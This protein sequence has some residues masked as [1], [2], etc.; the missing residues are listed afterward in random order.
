MRALEGVVTSISPDFWHG[1]RVLLTGATGFKGSWLAIWLMRLGARVSGLGLAAEPGDLFLAAGLDRKLDVGILDIRDRNALA[2]FVR[3]VQPE[4]VL[5]LAAQPLVRWS[6]TLPVETFETNVMGTV[7][8]LEACREIDGLRT[9]VAITTDKV[10]ANLERV[11]PYRED[12]H[13]GGHDPYSA[14]KA[15][16]EIAIQCYRQ[17]FLAERGIGLASAR[18][19]N[20]IGGGDWSKDRLLPDAIRAW[21]KGETLVIRRPDAVRPWQHV[22]EPLAGYL[23]LAEKLTADPALA[24]AY[25]F[26]PH[27][28]EAATVRTVVEL[29]RRSFGTAAVKFGNDQGPHEAG[30]LTLET[31]KARNVLGV[32]PVWTLEEAV[33]R[34]TNWY[35]HSLDGKD[36][37][38]LCEDDLDAWQSRS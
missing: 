22:V 32:A 13:L 38:R 14:S 1:R 4:I 9:I 2:E 37:F 20:V 36:A 8:V 25:N 3:A 23:V 26:G 12:D 24:D 17:S 30:L 29:A 31:A 5:H 34:T 16:C 33:D 10:Y 15:A 18:A 35:R 7:N 6:Y 27:T 28:H 21:S 11:L 19:G